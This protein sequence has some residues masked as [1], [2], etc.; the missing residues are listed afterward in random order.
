[1]AELKGDRE[2]VVIEGGGAGKITQTS[3]I[4][5]NQRRNM[6]AGRDLHAR[7]QDRYQQLLS[8]LHRM[9]LGGLGIPESRL[10]E[11]AALGQ[12]VGSP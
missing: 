10:E 7:G 5:S 1:M 4:S 8:P 11:W 12:V 6:E 3:G 9:H 2:N